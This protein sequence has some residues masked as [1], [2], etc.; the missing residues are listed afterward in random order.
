MF[1]QTQTAA[2]RHL[3]EKSEIRDTLGLLKLYHSA[4][5]GGALGQQ[6]QLQPC[7]D[8]QVVIDISP[9][10]VVDRGQ[11]FGTFSE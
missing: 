7:D 2:D 3:L 11:V 10:G 8:Q 5:R 9:T 4:Q 6:R 1:V